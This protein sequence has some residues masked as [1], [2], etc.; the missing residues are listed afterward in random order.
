MHPAPVPRRVPLRRPGGFRRE[1]F[2][3]G[4]TQGSHQE[5]EKKG[6]LGEKIDHD[7]SCNRKRAWGLTS[8][9]R[10][11]LGGLGSQK[12]LHEV[13]P[14]APH[15]IGLIPVPW[16]RLGRRMRSKSLFAAMSASTTTMVL[17][18]GTLESMEP[19]TRSSLPFRFPAT[20]WLAW[21]S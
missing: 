10:E 3:Q 14:S 21:L 13:V 17:L 2:A 20:N 19:W 8:S 12:V 11:L 9:E 18:G 5:E 1:G 16:P 4:K 15:H 7:D 6:L